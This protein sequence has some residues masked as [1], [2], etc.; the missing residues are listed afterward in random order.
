MRLCVVNLGAFSAAVLVAGSAPAQ[1]TGGTVVAL[2]TAET[3]NMLYAVAF[4]DGKV[5][6]RVALPVDPQNVVALQTGPAVVVSTKGHAVSILAWRTLRVEKIFTAFRSPHLATI[7]PDGEWAYVTDDGS[8]LLTVIRLAKP[9]I[10]RRLFVGTRAHHL[11]FRPDQRR[12]WIALGERAR[13]IVIVDTSHPARPRLLRRF[14]PGFSAHD[15]VFTPD[16]ARVWVT[17]ATDGRTRVLDGATRKLLFTVASG[18]P[19]QH[20]TFGRVGD[21]YVTSGYGSRIL[22]VDAQTG[23]VIRAA[24]SPYGSFNVATI[25]DWVLVSSLLRGTVTEFDAQLHVS[26]GT[27]V[28]PAA[29][30]IALSVWP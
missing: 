19:P 10:V 5:L 14:D 26:H 24:K 9:R 4:P 6:R 21:A 28:A 20:V 29:R 15:V 18:I 27:K 23:R 25:A 16:G 8:G 2:V 7:S 3:Q 1:P 13:T 22:R 11:T 12:L 30:G 17:S